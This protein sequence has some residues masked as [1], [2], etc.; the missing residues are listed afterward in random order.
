MAQTRTNESE[1]ENARQGAR[2]GN[3]GSQQEQSSQQSQS[4]GGSVVRQES[5]SRG[6]RSLSRA[7]SRQPSLGS[8][9]PFAAMRQLSRDMDRLFDSFF[10]PGLAPSP[11]DV[12]GRETFDAPALWSPQIDVQRRD[13][14]L[15]VRADLPGVRKEDLKIEIEDNAL[16]ISGQR[17]EERE[18]G[19]EGEGYQLYER[20]YG[21]FFRAIP[22]PQDVNAD[23]IKAEMRDGVLKVTAPLPQNAQRRRIQVQG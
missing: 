8:Q 5:G 3:G 10:G 12:G 18:E 9:H 16:V 2:P 4:Q 19:G 15:V 20:S 7:G 23:E 14:C 13:D 22:L 11:W 17:Q 21:S 6:G 1:S